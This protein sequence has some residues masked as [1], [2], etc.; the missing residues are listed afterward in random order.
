MNK[1]VEKKSLSEKSFN[2]GN[3][4]TGSAL[5]SGNQRK[6]NCLFCSGNHRA[7][8]CQAVTNLDGGREILKKQGRYF[9][10]LRREKH[11]A[12]NCDTKIYYFRCDGCHHFVVCH[13]S[14]G[15][16]SNNLTEAVDSPA[17]LLSSRMHVFLQTAQVNVSIPWKE[18]SHSLTVRAIFDTDGQR[19]YIIQKVVNA[20]KLRPVK[21]ERLKI[22]TFRDQKQKLEADNLV[23]L[24]VTKSGTDLN[25]KITLNA[26]AVPQI[27]NDL[28]GQDMKWVQKKYPSLKD[29]EFADVRPARSPMG[30]VD[31]S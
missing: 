26:F 4:P 2:S 19:S 5:L 28:Q 20:L 30:F 7:S 15:D 17:L 8:E 14:I 31:W 12:R 10:C 13:S 29:T 1:S 27:C 18:L 21:A 22:A 11:L 24:S 16:S 6:L 25:F 9:N 23:E 3:G